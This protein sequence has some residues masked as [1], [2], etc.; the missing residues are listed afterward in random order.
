[1]FIFRAQ[2]KTGEWVEGY[3]WK[4]LFSGTHFIMQPSKGG[5]PDVINS[6]VLP[7]TLSMSTGQLDKNKDMIFGSFEVDG[8]MSK[9]GSEII[10]YSQFPK[11][12]ICEQGKVYWCTKD[13]RW[14]VNGY[15][16][17]STNK[18]EIINKKDKE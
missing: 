3:H 8:K 15:G 6:P 1:M 17:T 7:E 18:F 16:F 5:M 9:G 14:K 11:G 4:N 2:K 13:L 12:L 10:I